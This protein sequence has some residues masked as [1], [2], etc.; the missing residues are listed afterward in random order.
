MFFETEIQGLYSLFSLINDSDIEVGWDISYCSVCACPPRD[1]VKSEDKQQTPSNRR[2]DEYMPKHKGFMY[3]PMYVC[4]LCS[5]YMYTTGKRKNPQ[6][7]MV[8]E[9]EER[10]TTKKKKTSEGSCV[11]MSGLK[12]HQ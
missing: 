5:H 3:V 7:K 6:A 4:T 11:R 12:L 8:K 1:M 10:P 2:N 9:G